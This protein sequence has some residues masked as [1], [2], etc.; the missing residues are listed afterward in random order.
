MGHRLSGPLPLGGR[1]DRRPPTHPP[2]LGHLTTACGGRGCTDLEWKVTYVGSAES[3][4][5]DQTLDAIFVGPV[6]L[7][8]NRF[9]F[10][11]RPCQKGGR[12]RGHGL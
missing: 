3:S 12:K 1:N 6:P 11:A 9:V 5:K 7:G 4:L 10:Q 2:L 8:V